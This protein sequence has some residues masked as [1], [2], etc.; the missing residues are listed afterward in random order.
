MRIFLIMYLC[1]VGANVVITILF[2]DFD[3]Q[4]QVSPKNL[5]FNIIFASFLTLLNIT[6]QRKHESSK[7]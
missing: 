6:R 3:V 5:L 2:T 7:A 4:E 1:V